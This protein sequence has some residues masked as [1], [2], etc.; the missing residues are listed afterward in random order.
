MW[1]DDI[2]IDHL[3]KAG[4]DSNMVTLRSH[5]RTG[6][7]ARC[8]DLAGEGQ[9]R[10]IALVLML[11]GHGSYDGSDYKFNLP[12]PDLSAAELATLLDTDSRRARKLVVNMTSASGGAMDA[13][14]GGPTRS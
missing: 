5:A 11:I 14:A 1:A 13:V 6:C 4:G 8:A 9:A 10:A 2:G 12:G 3:K 7:A